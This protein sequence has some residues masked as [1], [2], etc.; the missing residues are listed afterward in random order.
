MLALLLRLVLTGCSSVHTLEGLSVEFTK[1]CRHTHGE[2]SDE[3]RKLK[4]KIIF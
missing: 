2:S 1:N 4:E 3:P